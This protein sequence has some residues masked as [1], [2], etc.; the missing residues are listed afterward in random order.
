MGS[1]FQASRVKDYR[2]ARALYALT[3]EQTFKR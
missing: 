3:L 2:L 1:P